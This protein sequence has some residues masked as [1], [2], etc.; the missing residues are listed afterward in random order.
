MHSLDVDAI[1]GLTGYF[2]YIV[3]TETGSLWTP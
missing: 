1:V 2:V 3:Y